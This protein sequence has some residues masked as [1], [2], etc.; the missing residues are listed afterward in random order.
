MKRL[1][2][3]IT[4]ALCC[5]EISADTLYVPSGQYSTIQSAIDD[6]NNGDTI[7]ISA[8]TYLENI[9]F[10]GKAVILQSEDPNDPN[11]VATTIIDGSNPADPNIGSVV[12]F[13]KAED[14][15]S[16]LT[17]FTIQ[18]GT[19][20]TDPTVTWRG[21]DGENGD[22]G[23]A[24]CSNASPIITKNIFKDCRAEYGG[25][26]IFCHNGAS[27]VITHNTFIDNY[28]GWYG[29]GVFARASC[30]PTI[31]N[32]IFKYNTAHY[33]GG[34]IYLGG[35]CY[36]KVTNNW[37]E[38]NDSERLHGGAIYYF[39]NCS[40]IIACNF[41]IGNTCS[42]PANN[43]PTGSAILLEATTAG[44]VINNLFTGNTVINTHIRAATI[45][46]GSGSTDLIAN[47]IVYD[48]NNIGIYT[49]Q[50]GT[51][52]K[53]ND[54]WANA[55]GNYGGVTGDLTGTNGNISAD[56][57]VLPAFPEPLTL[58]EL[59]PNSPC[60]DAGAN[61]ALEVWLTEDYDGTS[62][63]V[64]GVVDM[65]PQEYKPIV[66]PTDFN[67]IQEAINNANDGDEIIVLPGFYRENV[68]FLT[69]NIRLRSLNPL[70]ANIVAQTIIDGNDQGSCIS[71]LSGQNDSTL[72][73]GLRLQNGHGQYGGGIHV[74]DS[75]GPMLMY[76]YIT[77]NTADS[78]GGGVDCRNNAYAEV[79]NNTIIDN[80]AGTAG[81]GVHIGPGSSCLIKNN[82]I[83]NN[84]TSGEAGGGIYTYDNTTAWI[85]DNVIKAN[86]AMCAW[87]GGIWQWDSPAGVIEGNIITANISTATSSGHGDGGRGGGIGIRN[88]DT[89]IRNNIIC[90]NKADEGGGIWV[91]GTG[92]AKISNNTIVGNTAEYAGSG[93]AIAYLA[94]YSITNN[95]ITNNGTTGGV[96]VKPD[97]SLPSEPNL[98]NNNVWNNQGGNYIG[99]INDLTGTEGN[100][101]ADPCLLTTGYW[102]DVNDT[103]VIVEP[104]DPNASWV[105]GDY[106]IP[107]F[108]PCRDAGISL[109]APLT[110]LNEDPRP[111]FDGFDI[112]AYELQIYDL[113]A[114]GTVD[115][116]DL[117]LLVNTWLN[118]APL[119]PADLDNNGIVDVRDFVL[120]GGDWARQN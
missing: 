105:F 32:N 67:T 46:S 50:A 65:G 113:S 2:L 76:N 29:G 20:Q 61:D 80:D 63:T 90:G 53:N 111:Y 39:V 37:F 108:S 116:T 4:L 21:W 25:G 38:K 47:N 55:A 100:I 36:S 60:I 119:I 44:K 15:N 3:V 115:F 91:Q 68:D 64:N 7:I 92:I 70:D 73:A 43:N 26:G 87:G 82:R 59:H 58:H 45:T 83:E 62:R 57:Q 35:Q 88:S 96:Y 97:G 1:L 66:V 24:H 79:L 101:S 86:K 104:N 14:A 51:V 12:T 19:G 85:I 117:L 81:G 42:G 40:P 98:M 8:G 74:N 41:F 84:F 77:N 107:Y 95:I 27:P 22:G 5:G 11:V 89:L 34:A 31:S 93:I 102:A 103:N 72:V 54:V 56:P 16:V 112:G 33:I 10:L 69:K 109:H 9:D 114:N 49:I 23:G 13:N 75:V 110:D 28:A 71:I 120:L 6:S 78:Y 18:N 17:G 106:H 118:K 48:N 94:A 30:S 99:E 52:I